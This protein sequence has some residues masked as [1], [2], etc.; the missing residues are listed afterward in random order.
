MTDSAL[1]PVSRFRAALARPMARVLLV[2]VVAF[3]LGGTTSLG[4]AFLVEEAASLAN[5]VTG[6]TLPTVALVFITARSFTEAAVA[7]AVSFVA[8][9][10]GYAVVSTLRGFP[11]DP[12]TWAVIGLLAGPVIGAATFALRRSPAEAAV[13]GGLLAGVLIGEGAYGLTVIADTTSPVFWWAAITVGGVLLVIVAALRLR[14]IRSTLVLVSLAGLTAVL[15]VVAYLA[16]P[17][18]FLLF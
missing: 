8:L 18:V 5:S 6:W 11:F 12:T 17:A 1:A 3:A 4:Q 9:T 2:A 16:L 15:F 10:V 13:G 14:D 7:G